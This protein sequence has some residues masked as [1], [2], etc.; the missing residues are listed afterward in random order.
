M[1]RDAADIIRG[2][3]GRFVLAFFILYGDRRMGDR[4]R[5]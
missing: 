1:I 2:R 5:R 4:G 3:L